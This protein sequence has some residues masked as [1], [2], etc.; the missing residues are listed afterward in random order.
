MKGVEDLRTKLSTTL[1]LERQ[2][3]GSIA[4]FMMPNFIVDLPGGGGKRL[5]CSYD[6]YDEE[7][8]I[9]TYT[10]PCVSGMQ[11]YTYYDPLP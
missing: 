4:G 6:S 5:A 10:A 11:K 7:A 1:H 9:A 8:G 2:I 3:R